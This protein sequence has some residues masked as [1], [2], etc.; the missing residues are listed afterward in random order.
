MALWKQWPSLLTGINGPT[1]NGNFFFFFATIAAKLAIG[2]KPQ[3][4][5]EKRTKSR[6]PVR[7]CKNFLLLFNVPGRAFFFCKTQMVPLVP[8]YVTQAA[9]KKLPVL[10]TLK[11]EFSSFINRS[12][13]KSDLERILFFFSFYLIGWG[14]TAGIHFVTYYVRTRLIYYLFI[15]FLA[16]VNLLTHST[17]ARYPHVTTSG[18][19]AGTKRIG[20]YGTSSATTEISRR[21]V[22]YVPPS[23]MANCFFF[24]QK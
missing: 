8:P 12:R 6:Q 9:Y 16:V 20:N 2:W 22:F 3:P 21:A 4:V 23:W 7:E 13:T 11:K 15:F 24:L 19:R 17:L 10:H 14:E 1:Y 18:R 5:T